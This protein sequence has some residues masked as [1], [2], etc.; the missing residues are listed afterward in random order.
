MPGSELIV[1]DTVDEPVVDLVAVDEKV[2][3]DGNAGDLVLSLG[4]Q[5]R[6]RGITRV[7]DQDGL[8]PRRDRRLDLGR[9]E[10]EVL[11]DGR[12]NADGDS[13]G[14]DDARPV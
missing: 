4:R 1:R 8:G 14:E 12:R 13:A 10:R 2:V 3:P 11:I 9:I 5:D 6:T 7:V